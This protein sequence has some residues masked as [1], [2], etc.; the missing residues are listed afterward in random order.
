MQ[1]SI[2]LVAYDDN[3]EITRICDSV[4]SPPKANEKAIP[5]TDAQ[6][7]QIVS[8]PMSS[9]ENPGWK[10]VN[11]QLT[12]P[13][14]PTPE[15]LLANA[16]QTKVSQLRQA[17]TLAISSPIPFTNSAGVSST[18]SFGNTLTPGG[19]NAQELL[20]SILSAGE[21]SWVAGVW[22]NSKGIAQAMTY[23]DLANLQKAIDAVEIPDEQNLLLKI[24]KVQSA[25]SVEEV[26][27]ISF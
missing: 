25:T 13:P 7:Q 22:M 4:D 19:S 15:R 10:V 26:E 16:K 1:Q 21:S 8:R 17:Y 18:Y 14:A 20:R 27:A 9:P 24:S 5:I 11:G 23:T 3:G 6:W 12:E 2:K